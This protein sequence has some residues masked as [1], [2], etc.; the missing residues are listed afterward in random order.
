MT[1]DRGR[2]IS[3]DLVQKVDPQRRTLLKLILGSAVVYAAPL[4]ASF[5]MQEAQ[6]ALA[7][8]Y[9]YMTPM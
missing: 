2:P 9:G 3:P 7:Q 4:V 6:V 5:P 8:G 1:D